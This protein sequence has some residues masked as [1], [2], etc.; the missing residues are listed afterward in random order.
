MWGE[1][2]R[3]DTIM[4][5]MIGWYILVPLEEPYNFGVSRGGPR[6]AP[7]RADADL[8]L[9]SRPIRKYPIFF[10]APLRGAGIASS[11]R[12]ATKARP[13]EKKWVRMPVRTRYFAPPPCA[14]SGPCNVLA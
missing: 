10:K 5:G 14:I 7:P 3:D 11:R 13:C 8:A 2:I 6:G 4:I 12:R 1:V 9:S